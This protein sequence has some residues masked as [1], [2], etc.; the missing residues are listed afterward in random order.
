[1]YNFA[2]LPY[3]S[4]VNVYMHHTVFTPGLRLNHGSAL[5]AVKVR[6]TS[7]ASQP[8]RR[9]ALLAQAQT[10]SQTSL[11]D[12]KIGTQKFRGGG[13][14]TTRAKEKSP[15]VA[16]CGNTHCLLARAWNRYEGLLADS[17]H[18]KRLRKDR[19][20]VSFAS[21]ADRHNAGGDR[22]HETLLDIC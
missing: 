4:R 20:N 6:L 3:S 8:N 11:P 16:V 18:A 12:P 17:E 21:P 7:H 9:F 14:K 5:G 22:R 19:I 15:V 1:M 2:H 10:H 13:T